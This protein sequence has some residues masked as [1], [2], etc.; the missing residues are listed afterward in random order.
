MVQADV[1]GLGNYPTF[2]KTVITIT[3]KPNVRRSHQRVLDRFSELHDVTV[4]DLIVRI[5]SGLQGDDDANG[6]KVDVEE[7]DAPDTRAGEDEPEGTEGLG[8]GMPISRGFEVAKGS[9][10]DLGKAW[11]KVKV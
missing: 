6:K 3:N 8:M 4:K 11:G 9:E 1:Q 10:A 7:D 2:S 5:L